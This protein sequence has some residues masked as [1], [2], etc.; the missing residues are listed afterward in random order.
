MEIEQCSEND[1]AIIL[2]IEIIIKIFQNLSGKEV[3]KC[4]RVCKL[5]KGA[6]D[7][8][9][10]DESHWQ[11]F[12]EEDYG[13]L[14]TKAR[15]KSALTYEGLYKSISLW[16]Q[17][18]WA[19]VKIKAL[20]IASHMLSFQILSNDVIG[21]PL[22]SECH[23]EPPSK[24]CVGFDYIGY[25]ALKTAN[26]ELRRI[27]MD[28]RFHEYKEN[29]HFVAVIEKVFPSFIM[30]VLPKNNP[31]KII[32]QFETSSNYKVIFLHQ[33]TLYYTHADDH[34]ICCITVD[35]T[36]AIS[37]DV[38]CRTSDSVIPLY[39]SHSDNSINFI[40]KS[41][42]IYT[43]SSETYVFRQFIKPRQLHDL[44]KYNFCYSPCRLAKGFLIYGDVILYGSPYG[45]LAIFNAP[46]AKGPFDVCHNGPSIL[47]MLK[48]LVDIMQEPSI[49]CIDVIEVENGHDVVVM[50]E[51]A[52]IIITLW[53]KSKEQV[54][55]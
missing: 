52:L 49:C 36:G 53:H 10:R 19:E 29:E 14:Y 20:L 32:Y 41:K 13:K 38:V 3:Y 26:K 9:F 12:Y 37:D 2:P 5:W 43:L 24:K 55:S 50:T 48:E 33:D 15:N 8:L 22:C 7:L 46:V 28:V 18:A 27:Y 17:M 23:I 21:I 51:E 47:F 4:R 30:S 45:L 25:Y 34:T 1:D 42:A 31:N 39:F 54:E 44:R 11:K 6:A 16:S 40:S 35:A